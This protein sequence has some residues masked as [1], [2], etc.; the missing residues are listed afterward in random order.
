MI[1]YKFCVILVQIIIIDL[2]DASMLRS[3]LK[4]YALLAMLPLSLL[5]MPGT[6]SAQSDFG[7]C[8]LL[9]PLGLPFGCS[10][11]NFGGG[12]VVNDYILPRVQFILS[13]LFIGLI[14]LSIF[15]VVK[16]AITYIQSQGNP[17]KIGEAT[18]SIRSVFIGLGALFVGI[19]GILIVL[20]FF[21][22]PAGGIDDFDVRCLERPQCCVDGA[23]NQG[24][25]PDGSPCP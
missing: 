1:C 19:A 11:G 16:A 18:K 17:E 24:T 2:I 14:V 15:Y 9:G 25:A 13:L 12:N 4:K 7:V 23:Y 20:A 22:G 10:D 3:N 8:T 5:F 21:G 6:V